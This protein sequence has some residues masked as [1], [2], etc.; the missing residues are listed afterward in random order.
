[1]TIRDDLL[2]QLANNLVTHTEFSVNTELPFESGGNPLYFKNMRTVYLDKQEDS[3]LQLFR[4]LDQGSVYTTQTV[5]NGYM[6]VDAKNQP[7]D[8]DT[9]IANVLVARN[10]ITETQE[11]ESSFESSIED[12]VL[13]YTFEYNITKLS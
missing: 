12:D 6:A 5:V 4:T 9:V 1:M 10:V 8:I 13:T 3:K 2:A 7:L 11:N